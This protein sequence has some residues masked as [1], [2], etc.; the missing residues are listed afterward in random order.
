MF[1][2]SAL[3]PVY[4]ELTTCEHYLIH[5]TDKSSYFFLIFFISNSIYIALV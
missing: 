1:K 2:K 4:T 3:I 5:A